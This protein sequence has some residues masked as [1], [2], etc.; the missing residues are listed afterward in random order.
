VEQKNY[1]FYYLMRKKYNQ[2]NLVQRYKIEAHVS[3]G[4]N[5]TVIASI[6]GVHRSTFC[7]ELKCNN[8]KIGVQSSFYVAEMANA[9]TKQRHRSK[10]KHIKLTQELKKQASA[11]IT[12]RRFTP[13]LI[14]AE[15]RKQAIQGV[16]HE[17]LYP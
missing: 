15:R 9:K 12:D 8:P 16:R 17:I 1:L 6:L 3:A 7:G 5:Q 4:N 10:A 13:K 2:L 14:S 11:C